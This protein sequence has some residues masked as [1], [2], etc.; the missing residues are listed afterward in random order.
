MRFSSADRTLLERKGRLP[1]L[2]AVGSARIRLNWPVGQVE[3]LALDGS[4]LGKIPVEKK[5]GKLEFPVRVRN[6]PQTAVFCYR[7]T[8]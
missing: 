6:F 4:V 5:N 3:A 8:R 1:L 2:A 7:I